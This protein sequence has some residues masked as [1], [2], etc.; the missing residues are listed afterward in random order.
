MR[1]NVEGQRWCEVA[2]ETCH[3][4]TPNRPRSMN[5]SCSAAGGTPGRVQMR[6]SWRSNYSDENT[7]ERREVP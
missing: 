3:L 6:G 7:G 2:G 4:M 5:V 1:M